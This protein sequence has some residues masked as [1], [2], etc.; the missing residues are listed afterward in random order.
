MIHFACIWFVKYSSITA[1]PCCNTSVHSWT[2]SWDF[3]MV[4]KRNQ[5]QQQTGSSWGWQVFPPVL[6]K[7][8]SHLMSRWYETDSSFS[9]RDELLLPN[10][11]N[12]RNEREKQYSSVTLWFPAVLIK[13]YPDWI[14]GLS[15][16]QAC[17]AQ[18]TGQ[19]PCQI[20][21][22]GECAQSR[23]MSWQRNVFTTRATNIV[24][25]NAFFSNDSNSL[26]IHL[27]KILNIEANS[28]DTKFN[29]WINHQKLVLVLY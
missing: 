24:S 28:L 2:C 7:H 23:Y 18:V 29:I 16:R 22:Y 17:W 6:P 11:K 5:Q 9:A 1:V 4:C 25:H 26:N 27:N 14:S 21:I 10:G 19:S 15:P 8:W 13:Q 20:L 3:I 12:E